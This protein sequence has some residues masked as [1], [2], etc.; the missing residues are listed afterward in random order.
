MTNPT[1]QHSKAYKK[2]L[3]LIEDGRTEAAACRKHIADAWHYI[4]DVTNAANDNVV[5]S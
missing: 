1:T 3:R 4:I 2:A 5:H